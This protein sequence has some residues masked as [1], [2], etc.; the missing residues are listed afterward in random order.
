MILILF[1]HLLI[2]KCK[3]CF[4]RVSSISWNVWLLNSFNN[5]FDLRASS[6][7]LMESTLLS[8]HTLY[9]NPQFIFKS[10]LTN[11]SKKMQNHSLFSM[12]GMMIELPHPSSYKA[13]LFPTSDSGY[14]FPHCYK[15]W[16]IISPSSDKGNTLPPPPHTSEEGSLW[17]LCDK[18]TNVIGKVISARFL[19]LSSAQIRAN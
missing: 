2:W 10:I 1:S 6:V 7:K 16:N 4:Y 9:L 12:Q 19:K 15:C 13:F 3:Y 14:C 8:H 5:T 17:F 11:V 18:R